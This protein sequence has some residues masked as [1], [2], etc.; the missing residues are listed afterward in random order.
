MSQLKNLEGLRFGK[1]LVIKR[2]ENNK[3]GT[4]RW[5]CKCD[6]GNTVLVSSSG[7]NN[8]TSTSCG[9]YARE[10]RAKNCTK[11][12]LYGTRIYKIYTGMKQRCLNPK[13]TRYNSYG[14]RGIKICDEW[15]DK[16]YGVKNF[17]NWAIKNGYDDT[18]SLDRI[19]NEGNYEPTN[20][21]WATPK[22]QANNRRDNIRRDM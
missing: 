20:C 11:H 3:S 15:L 12:S 16:E 7:L 17:Y 19:D 18:L 14:G 21:R 2:G 13:N 8:G 22:E 1:L 4:A 9:C 5:I 10:I 6:C